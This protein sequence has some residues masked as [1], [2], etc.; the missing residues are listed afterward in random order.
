M[1]RL[2]RKNERSR[3]LGKRRFESGWTNAINWPCGPIKA[4]S[5]A[6][7]ENAEDMRELL[8]GDDFA[9]LDA[10][11]GGGSCAVKVF[12]DCVKLY[13]M[14]LTASHDL[15]LARETADAIISTCT[16]SYGSQ[17]FLDCDEEKFITMFAESMLSHN[18]WEDSHTCEA[19]KIPAVTLKYPI[20]REQLDEEILEIIENPKDYEL[21]EEI[22]Y[23][24]MAELAKDG[25]DL[26]DDED[27]EDDEEYESRRR[28]VRARVRNEQAV[29]DIRIDSEVAND[30]YDRVESL[31]N[32]GWKLYKSKFG[33]M[34]RDTKSYRNLQKIHKLLT[35]LEI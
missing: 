22:A 31:Y 16:K 28:N 5:S 6:P 33:G 3:R 11:L 27:D 14:R 19:E 13:H 4:S 7:V 10:D 12:N 23:D 20:N 26:S 15:A 8:D 2:V 18:E 35:E 9:Y 17:E 29:D 1:L 25:I 34:N 21:C 30:L 32:D 24:M